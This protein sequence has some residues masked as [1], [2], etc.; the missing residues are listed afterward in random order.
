[1]AGGD[2]AAGALEA[3]LGAA[4]RRRRLEAALRGA[5]EGA[6]YRE[7]TVPLLQPAA[8]G[9]GWE[10][11]YRVLDADGG[12]MD[13]RPDVTGPVARLCALGDRGGVRPRRLW[14]QAAIFRRAPG[15]GPR[16]VLQAGAERIGGDGGPEADAELLSLVARCLEAAGA[17]G[18][19]LALGDAGYA[20]A[21]AEAAGADAD[22]VLGALRRRDFAALEGAACAAALRWRGDPAAAR[23]GGLRA[24]L[25]AGRRW[26]RLLDLLEGAGLAPAVRVAP[27]LLLPGAYY[28]GLVFEVLVPGVPWPV[29]D[30]GRYDGLLGRWG[31]SEPAVGFALDCDRLLLSL[32]GEAP[33]E[34][35]R[36]AWAAVDAPEGG[37]AR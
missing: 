27:G 16:E 5:L 32:H 12:V 20:R 10:A 8:A 28:T 14:Y 6:G 1:V 17:S 22:S 31:A 15:R 11:A 2:R 34:R 9:D 7:V 35:A 13:L 25:P 23:T 33:A 3:V 30:G 36:R 19:L 29:G 4:A 18:F 26:L 21:C 24:D 37:G